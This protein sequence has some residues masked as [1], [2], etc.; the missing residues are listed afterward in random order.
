MVKK[1]N[2][3]Q[4]I[5]IND[6]V[7]KADYNTK[8]EEIEKKIHNDDKDITTKEF[9]KFTEENFGVRLK[10]AKLVT[11]SDIANF[12]KEKYFDEKLINI[13]RKVTLY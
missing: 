10:Q 4:T 1:V 11:K 7:K 6:L 8:I 9:D 2:T 3:I 5:N 12:V 13:N